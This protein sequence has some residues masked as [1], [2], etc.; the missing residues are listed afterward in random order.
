VRH[1]ADL[2]DRDNKSES[3]RQSKP[4]AALDRH[5]DADAEDDAHPIQ[6]GKAKSNFM[7]QM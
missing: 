5:Q 3:G 6:T 2:A 7:E 4:G 1:A